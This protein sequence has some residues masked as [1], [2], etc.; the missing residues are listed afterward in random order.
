M[1]KKVKNTVP[2]SYVIS[3][4]GGEKRVG[5]F[6]EKGLKKTSQTKF[7][8]KKVTNRKRNRLYVK[9]KGYDHSINSWS[10]MKG[11]V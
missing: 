2:C 1:I 8:F 7:R 3:D 11:I 9:L 6:Y 4:R 10:N 5:A